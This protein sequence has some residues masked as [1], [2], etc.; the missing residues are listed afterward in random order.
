MKESSG[1]GMLQ[2]THDQ[3]HNSNVVVQDQRMSME[4]RDDEGAVHPC[5]DDC[6]KLLFMIYVD[7][8]AHSRMM[9]K[10][11]SRRYL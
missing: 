5:V 1:L 7:K 10:P 3:L 11:M 9:K 4:P 6:D 2:Q 8:L